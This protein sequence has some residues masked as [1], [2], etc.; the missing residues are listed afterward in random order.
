MQRRRLPATL[1]L[2]LTLIMPL[3]AAAEDPPAPT[4]RHQFRTAGLAPAGPMEVV[5]WVLDFAPGA[6]TPPHTHPGLL[7]GTQIEGEMTFT[8]GGTDTVYKTGDTVIEQPG[9]VGVAT[10]NGAVRNRAIVSLVTPQGGPPSTPQPGAPAP[11]I[12]PVTSYLVRVPA[13]VPTGP[14]DQVSAILDFA[15]GTQT[16]PQTHAGQVVTT[17]LAGE[18]IVATGGAEKAYKAG[19]TFVEPPETVAQIRN[20]G[21]APATLASTYLLQQGAPLSAPITT[22]GLPNT[23]AGGDGDR[24]PLGWL[25]LLVG[26]ALVLT[27]GRGLRRRSRAAGR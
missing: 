13:V 3:T 2:A 10:N 8:S 17:V 6:A 11:A 19:E 20:A 21:A 14:Y 22:P 5:K 4:I 18:V 9:V 7:L 12:P 24:L 15:P 1:L 26:G 27:A 16:P 25:A 23:G